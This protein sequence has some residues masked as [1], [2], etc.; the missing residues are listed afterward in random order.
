MKRI[1]LHA[2]TVLAALLLAPI[3][4]LRGADEI[5]L[6]MHDGQ[7]IATGTTYSAIVA[8][9][10]LLSE[11][12][13]GTK[14]FVAQPLSINTEHGHNSNERD[15]ACAAIAQPEPNVLVCGGE[16]ATIR[17]VFS[18]A[19]LTCQIA[20]RSAQAF[21]F[22][23]TLN[24]GVE[25]IQTS[26]RDGKS[27]AFAGAPASVYGI[28]EMKV[29]YSGQMLT[30]RGCDV[31][32][33][34]ERV[35]LDVLPGQTRTLALQAAPATT[36]ESALFTTPSAYPEPLTVLAPRDWQ[37]FQ[38]QTREEGAVA[39]RGRFTGVC[40]R[41]EFRLGTDWHELPLNP[42]THAFNT[43]VTLPAGGWYGCGIRALKDGKTIAE[44]S[45]PHVGIG[46]VFVGA[47]Q[48][49][50]TNSGEEKLQPTSGMVST[51]SGETWRPADDPQ[52]GVHDSSGKGSFYPALGDA[53]ARRFKVPIAFAVTGHGGTSV[54]QWTPGGELFDWMENRIL[55]LGPEG[56]RAVLWHQGE[57]ETATAQAE[58]YRRLKAIIE[59]SNQQAGWCFPWIVAQLGTPGTR[60]AR[61]QLDADG[62]AFLGPDT[63]LLKGENRGNGGKD[64][65]FSRIGLIHHGEAWAE[66]IVPWLEA[67]LVQQGTVKVASAQIIVCP[68]DAPAKV[69]LAAKEIR[70]YV[71]LRTGKL[72]P[73]G[74][75]GEGIALKIDPSLGS[76]EYRIK[77]DRISGG[78]DLGVL[79]GAYR[80]AELLGVRFYLHGDVVPDRQLKELPSVNDTGK[81]LFGLRGVNPWGSH[82]FGFDAW[83]ADDYKAI[84]TQLAK[85]RMNFI[86]MH[87][88]PEGHP[89]AEPTVWHGLPGDFD[90]HGR[91]KNSYVS[92]YFNTLLAPAWGDY[93]PRKTSDYSFG[94]A[95]LFSD[96]AWAPDVLRGH[97]PLPVTPEECNDVFNRMGAQ[98]K[99]AFTFARQ[100]GVKTCLGTEAPLVMPKTL[101]NRTNDVR[102]VYEGTFR[103]IMASHPL[104]Y[105]W[106]WTPEGWTWSGN[107]P[108]QYSSTVAD[109]KLA[110][111][112]LKS[113]DAPFQLATCGWV[114]GPQH[115]RSAFDNDLPKNIP[116]SGISR[117]TG[118]TE[119]DAS[120][121][122][123]S[124]REKWAIPWLESD[125]R[126]GLGGVQLFAGRMRRDAADAHDY[127]CTGLMGLHWRTEILSPNAAALAQAAWDQSWNKPAVG[128]KPRY[129]PVD[130]F[131]AD[132]AQANF[133]LAEAGKIFASIDGKVPCVTNGGCPSGSLKPETTEWAK[134]AP[135]FNFVTE[136]ESL[137]GRI[138]GAGNLDRYDYWVNTFKYLRA[139]MK[140]RCA[141]GMKQPEG[142]S[143]SW[144]EAYTCLLATVNTPGALAM[145]VNMGNHP[146][147][148]ATLGADATQP[149]PKEYQGKPRLI[150][151]CVRSLVNPNEVLKLKIIALANQ[152]ATPVVHLR[153]LGQGSWQ[154]MRA[155]HIA[156]AV[157]EANLPAARDDFEYYITAGDSLVWPATAPLL[158]Q[159]V[160]ITE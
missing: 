97:C 157:Y 64:V 104:D 159:T 71:Y 77:A 3:S 75:T 120:F 153:P 160:V 24:H 145:V 79:Y 150:V 112:A 82:P 47:G 133:G 95:L 83:S 110:I 54:E 135:R 45:I 11:L 52:P 49:N 38:R 91:V 23:L 53:L 22:W 7:Y 65:H 103:R 30:L 63:D 121:G 17:Y 76:E 44:Q 85:M 68:S 155:T 8:A 148:G 10:G 92:R 57:A 141:M 122:K 70:R 41:L 139:I 27:V 123:I 2:V 94:G 1:R 128:K 69:K 48:S 88:Y 62:V 117:S 151:P 29:Y 136:L 28:Q 154:E 87:C 84:I 100:L 9:T 21:K 89:Y 90:E 61:V 5:R 20:N 86:G 132:W 156:R 114:L 43:R 109:I 33:A 31:I 137:R 35:R 131:Y 142:V 130:D 111:E 67:Q 19:G 140:V 116:M 107:K 55:Q 39:I 108:E 93:R 26:S 6:A 50:S 58:Y 16:A 115:D 127:G 13:V 158:N 99:D 25:G 149:W 152:P 60:K 143:K 106:I 32:Y 118:A 147:W 125:N 18:P 119:V 74:E 59:R 102:A 146:G 129:L 51:F 40:D 56:F 138:T 134:I 81:P 124:G 34:S 72:L 37:V 78:S 42:V 4:T 144:R 66:K 98:F 12:K 15:H 126:E 101:A 105:Y 113:V 36:E 73:I 80:Y 96:D 46:E 14:V